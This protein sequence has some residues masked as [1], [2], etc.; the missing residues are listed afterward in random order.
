MCQSLS[1]TKHTTKLQFC[2][3][4]EGR[5]ADTSMTNSTITITDNI[6]D[7]NS[8]SKPSWRR[9]ALNDA[10]RTGNRNPTNQKQPRAYWKPEG[11]GFFQRTFVRLIV[12]NEF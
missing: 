12:W 6:R 2:S 1:K 10:P 5:E 3:E 11:V 9:S 4:R 7:Q 8:G